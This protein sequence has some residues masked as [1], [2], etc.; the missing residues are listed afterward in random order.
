VISILRTNVV[1]TKDFVKRLLN[2]FSISVKVLKTKR[3]AV[4]TCPFE[5]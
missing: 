3:F 4:A 2:G 1:K 5:I